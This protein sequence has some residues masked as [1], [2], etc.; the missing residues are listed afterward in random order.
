MSIHVVTSETNELLVFHSV[1]RHLNAAKAARELGM[2]PSGVSRVLSRLEERLG[3]R[4]LQRTTRK[5]ALTQEGATFHARTQQVITDLADAEAEVQQNALRPRGNVRM[6]APVVLGHLHLTPV[7]GRLLRLHP[8]LGVDLQLVD[9]MVDIVDEGIDLAIRVGSLPD[10]RLIAR[11]LCVNWRVLVASPQ[12]L[13]ERGVPKTPE[14]LTTHEC[15]LFTG[16]ARPREWRLV[17]PAGELVVPV[18]GRVSC[19]NIEVLADS[20]A[21][22][23]GIA[24]GATLHAGPLLQAGKLVRVLPDYEFADSA[25]FAVFPSTR[26]LSTKVRA[27][28]DFLRDEWRD[29]PLWDVALKGVVPG[30]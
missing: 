5:L 16:F 10:S 7:L 26:Q 6:T 2:T 13:E 25:I 12:Y 14:D 19:N 28:V 27:T 4:L 30:F 29:P 8:E 20:A 11:R 17:G 15:L 24:V 21:N 1:V 3:V 9:R 23:L 22:G 18:S